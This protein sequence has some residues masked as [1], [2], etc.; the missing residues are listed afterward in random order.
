MLP[1]TST[2]LKYLTKKN[3]LKIFINS[4]FQAVIDR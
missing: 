2:E 1:N 3:K 4:M